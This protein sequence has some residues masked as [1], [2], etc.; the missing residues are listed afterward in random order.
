MQNE[1]EWTPTIDARVS[2][3]IRAIHAFATWVIRIYGRNSR[4]SDDNEDDVDYHPPVSGSYVIFG[5]R[6]ARIISR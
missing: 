4:K 6:F 1:V 5:M 3:P 2:I